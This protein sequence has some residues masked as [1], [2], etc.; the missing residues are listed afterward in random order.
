MKTL[1]RIIG[2]LALLGLVALAAI[3]WV[4]A[5]RTGPLKTLAANYAPAKGAGEAVAH[6]ADCVACHTAPGGVPYAGGRKIETPMGVIVATNITP[7]KQ[8]GIGA[9]TLDEFRAVLYDGIRKDGARLYPAMPYANYRKMSEEDVRAL[10]AF[11][12]GEVAAAPAMPAKTSLSFPYNQRWGLRL[13][14]WVALPPAGFTPHMGDAKLDRGAYLVEALGHCGACHTPRNALFAEKGYDAK[15]PDFLTGGMVGPWPATD[16]R[17]MNSHVQTWSDAELTALL[18][19]GRNSTTGVAGE[20]ALTIEHSLQYLPAADIEAITTYL[21]AIRQERSSAAANNT[22]EPPVP[23]A[24]VLTEAKQLDL[25]ARLYLDNCNACHF[26][27]GRGATGVFPR[28]DRN[29]LVTAPAASGLVSVILEGAATPSTAGR[30]E[31][32]RMPGMGW[33]L[34]D[35]EVAALA[36]F[37]RRS[38]SN[39]AAAVTAAE[40]KAVRGSSAAAAPPK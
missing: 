3:I 7:D 8:T 30:P 31:R 27:N 36:T 22:R 16:L 25:G 5:K 13:W 1:L 15:S 28:L 4:P 40:V 21:K 29:E 32:L 2:S 24:A 19:Q 34:N 38:W 9:Y 18:S 35:E 33:R 20:M 11:F 37:V 39:N 26:T 6:A 10:Y 17:A 23:T 14:N 12:M